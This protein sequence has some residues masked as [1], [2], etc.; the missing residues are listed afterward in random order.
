MILD[1]EDY[2]VSKPHADRRKKEEWGIQMK[3]V[4]QEPRRRGNRRC[5][6]EMK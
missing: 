3:A 6:K 1:T 4:R 2:V 5:L